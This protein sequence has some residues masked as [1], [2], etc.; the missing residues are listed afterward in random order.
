MLTNPTPTVLVVDDN[1]D[2]LVI[3]RRILFSNGF[4]VV[5]AQTA[6]NA[7]AALLATPVD[8]ALLDICLPDSTGPAL[9]QR[10]LTMYPEVAPIM[11]TGETELSTALDMLRMGA[12]DFVAKP[13]TPA[14][15]I[16]SITRSLKRRD[17][18]RHSLRYR[19]M[20]EHEVY[21]RACAL[22]RALG[23]QRRNYDD[24]IR[25]L[26]A[27][28]D[29]RD[30]ETEHHCKRVAGL[31]LRL[32]IELGV[33]DQHQLQDLKWGAYLHDIGKIGVPDGILS[34]PGR[35]TPEEFEMIKHHA[36][37]G[38][39]ILKRVSFLTTAAKVV[40]YHHERYDGR[41]YPDGLSGTSIPFAARVFAVADSVD[42][43]SA[44]RVYS[45]AR[46]WSEIRAELRRCAAKQF[47]PLVVVAFEQLSDHELSRISLVP[48]QIITT[49]VAEEVEHAT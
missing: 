45:R 21:E 5:T 6:E 35:V 12:Y 16:E 37:Y 32:A 4:R 1:E 11:V 34:K 29:L 20:L 8:I 42:A 27:A 49:A 19:T 10:V 28:L 36:E 39:R 44:D 33:C 2:L 14:E 31:A 9:L 24:T 26:G 38:A 48:D 30:P 46:S 7:L 47:D 18:E 3:I 40:R 41:G 23:E 25:A 15:L 43:M 13:F 17:R 22:E